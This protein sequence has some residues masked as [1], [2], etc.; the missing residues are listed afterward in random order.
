MTQKSPNTVPQLQQCPFCLQPVGIGQCVC[1]ACGAQ[2][3]TE[4]VEGPILGYFAAVILMLGICAVSVPLAM[5]GMGLVIY[6]PHLIGLP[7]FIVIIMGVVSFLWIVVK[8]PWMS[9]KAL[10][11]LLKKT[12]TY[13]LVWSRGGHRI[14]TPLPKR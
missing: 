8:L 2:H 3:R 7:D 1:L 13:Y 6:I 10:N 12:S 11:G 5:Y 9:W 14:S 4:E